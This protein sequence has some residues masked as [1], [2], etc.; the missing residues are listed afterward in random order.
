MDLNNKKPKKPKIICT[1]GTT[2]DEKSIL[3]GMVKAGMRCAR[4]NT[5]YAKI[6]EY[7]AR[8]ELLR[9][10]GDIPVMMDLKGPQVRLAASD[11]IPIEHDDIII[12]G[13]KDEPVHFSKDFYKDV[14]VNDL[15]F[16]ENGDIRT[17]V[18]NKR[19]NIISLKVIEPGPGMIHKQMGVNVPGKYLDV[20]LLS[21]KD[22]EVI[23]FSIKNN[24]E[25]IALSFVRDHNDIKNL[26]LYIEEQKE[27]LGEHEDYKPGIVAKIEDRYGITNLR[28]IIRYSNNN[29]INLSVMFGRGDYAVERPIVEL[30]FAQEYLVNTCRKHGVLSIIGTGIL[31]SMQYGYQPTRAETGDVFNILRQGADAFML[32]GETSNSYSDP[33]NTTQKLKSMVDLYYSNA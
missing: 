15:V 19:N 6:E 24:I 8:V 31:E 23:D 22:K 21:K 16:I 12:A 20:E 33:V 13:F 32:S 14:K 10:V 28:D 17:K 25:Y 7:Q 4:M 11:A 1:L 29:D 5:A 27:V 9:S 18:S 2:T 30:P 26:C 3:E